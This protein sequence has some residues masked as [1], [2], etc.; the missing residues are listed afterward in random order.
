[1]FCS[2]PSRFRAS[3][4]SFAILVLILGASQCSFA[5]SKPTT[6]AHKPPTPPAP[7]AA[8]DQEQFISY[9]TTE[10][11]WQTELQLRNNAA[12]QDLTVTPALRLPS[13]AETT[14]AA[15]TI[16]P[17]EVKSID[18]DAAIPASAPQLIGTYGSVVLR[19]SSSHF[20]GLYAVAMIHGVGHSIAFHIDGMGEPPEFQAASREGIWW[21][22][23]GSARDY[24]VLVN[25]GQDPLSLT[26]SL[27]D[28]SGKEFTQNLNLAPAAMTRLSVRQLVASAG[29]AGTYGGIKASASNHGGALNSLHVLFD[30]NSG[31]SAI[32]KMFERDP[33]AKLPERDYAKTGV[34]TL[35]A[36]MLALSN[37][38]PAL[39]FP[40]GTKLRPEVFVHNAM[41]KP[42][43][44][45]LL[46]NWRAAT[47]SGKAAGP[48][49]HLRPF[50]TRF[51]DVAALQDGTILP[52][53]ANWTSVTLTSS[54][55]PDELMAVAASYDQTL[56]YGAQTP[57][58]DQLS[59]LWKG[60]TWEFD[61]YHSSIITA[62]NGGTKPTRAAFTIFYN[63]GSEKY[64]LE[65]TLQPDEQMWFDIGKLISQAVPDK[66]GK[67]MPGDL[68][69]G[70]YEFRDLGNSGL[71]VLFEGK[72]I[73]DKTY[74]HVTYGCATCCG[75][76]A[77][78]LW[79]DPMVL[80][81]EGPAIENGVY[82]WGVC[83]QQWDDT[84]SSFYGNWGSG[85]TSILTVDTYGNETGVGVG[86]TTDNT[87][88]SIEGTAHY[89]ICPVKNFT[90]SGGGST[91]TL[92]CTPVSVTRGN[93]VT[94]SVSSAP[95]GATFSHWKFTDSSSN[96]VTT[97]QSTSSWSGAAVTGGTVTV[98]VSSTGGNTLTLSASFTVTARSNFAFTAVSP[99][100]VANNS[101]PST[102]CSTL[103]V[104]SPPVQNS[105]V[106]VSCLDQEFSAND[107]AVSD[108]GPNQGYHY[109]TSASNSSSGIATGYYYV[110]S[111][112]LSNTSSAFYFAQTGT[113]DP[114]TNPNGYISGANLLAD[115]IRHESGNVNAHYENYVLAQNNPANDVGVV[116][117]AQTGPPGQSTTT[118]ETNVTNALK[119]AAATIKSAMQ[120]QPCNQSYTGY[121]ATCTFQGYVNYNF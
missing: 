50:E 106:G 103:S 34:W 11:G 67:T 89:P 75:Y 30:E 100:S 69:S 2:F 9:W 29:L 35:R 46:F 114:Q 74:G 71:G 25:Q 64:Q 39:A 5:Q 12:A 42:V 27:Y 81:Y 49:L 19:Y 16:K 38:D 15:V 116:A 93:S 85:S 14:L 101:T 4:G 113:Y 99:T 110:I 1:M 119:N 87:F 72:V 112:D 55:N 52:K 120:V 88:G 86:S 22:P 43:D 18:L 44:A 41:G 53:D 102:A 105:A 32:L 3:F 8:V 95:T 20:S 77:A 60:G 92:T 48:K 33:S 47:S 111:P 115:T 10:T 94:C 62:G 70:S 28:A 7:P 13:G 98:Q 68:T 117:E 21:L 109:V 51:V 31:F 45:A 61:A 36:P 17:Q 57:F 73:Y 63:Q 65:Q 37:P 83:D 96:T 91:T 82:G 56:K 76:N 90:P 40:S 26:L 66:N 84:S 78:Q 108:S 79:N 107:Q 6:P 59:H 97:T 23:S 121:D 104:P 58:S 54:A 118:F 80:L 24:L